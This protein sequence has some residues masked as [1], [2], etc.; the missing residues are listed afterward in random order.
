MDK[1]LRDSLTV[2]LENFGYGNIPK[3]ENY[4]ETISSMFG[5]PKFILDM[6]DEMYENWRESQCGG[7]TKPF[8]KPE[9]KKDG[10]KMITAE[11]ARKITRENNEIIGDIINMIN[12]WIKTAAENGKYETVLEFNEDSTLRK[13]IINVKKILENNNYNVTFEKRSGFDFY[14]YYKLSISWNKKEEK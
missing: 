3:L 6:S 1:L 10:N 2:H 11:E 5:V 8:T 12:Y 7:F 13:Y 14:P 4:N 9:I